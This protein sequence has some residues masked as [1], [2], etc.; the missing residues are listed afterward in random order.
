MRFG[1]PFAWLLLVLVSISLSSQA[2]NKA[3][4]S[5]AQLKSEQSIDPLQE[6]TNT[7]SIT[8]SITPIPLP[9]SS[10]T[11]LPLPTVLRPTPEIRPFELTNLIG[12]SDAA[13]RISVSNNRALVIAEGWLV[14]MDLSQPEAAVLSRY[15]LQSTPNDVQHESVS[16]KAFDVRGDRVA[17]IQDEKLRFLKH[18]SND[19]ERLTLVSEFQL[20]NSA[21]YIAGAGDVYLIGLVEPSRDILRYRAYRWEIGDN[22][23]EVAVVDIPETHVDS[24]QASEHLLAINRQ[25]DPP[26]GPRD[27]ALYDISE[28]DRPQKIASSTSSGR[29]DAIQNENILVVDDREPDGERLY[30]A[31]LLARNSGSLDSLGTWRG[32]FLRNAIFSEGSIL[33]ATD[34]RNE[35][36]FPL[37][38]RLHHL[39]ANDGTLNEVSTSDHLSS[40]SLEGFPWTFWKGDGRYCFPF[41]WRN[42][43]WIECTDSTWL[44]S[45][46]YPSRLAIDSEMR[47]DHAGDL[48]LSD[49][50]HWKGRDLVL[51]GDMISILEP[52]PGFEENSEAGILPPWRVVWKQDLSIGGKFLEAD[53]RLLSHAAG[54]SLREI[55]FSGNPAQPV[56]LTTIPPSFTDAETNG[57]LIAGVIKESANSSHIKVIDASN[58]QV[59]GETS[60]DSDN[61]IRDWVE[62]SSIFEGSKYYVPH[63]SKGWFVFDLADSSNPTLQ[64]LLQG[65]YPDGFFA[66]Q[67]Y[68][69]WVRDLPAVAGRHR[70]EL[71]VYNTASPIEDGQFQEVTKIALD[72]LP[73]SAD[74]NALGQAWR[75]YRLFASGNLLLIA[76]NGG[77]L[78]RVDISNPQSP[79]LLLPEPF[80]ANAWSGSPLDSLG[81]HVVNTGP[82]YL[83]EQQMSRKIPE[84]SELGTLRPLGTPRI[85]S[86]VLEMIFGSESLTTTAT[87]IPATGAMT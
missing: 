56:E 8:P 24:I 76:R 14:L 10:P 2:L 37:G 52:K 58:M 85:I 70:A 74:W 81:Q 11:T 75:R 40:Q 65:P 18:P 82:P 28:L 63:R 6:A 38:V 79:S 71:T 68:A 51:G 61:G 46:F 31:H 50:V 23:S 21:D 41:G 3:Y 19:S 13:V 9:S 43:H 66:Y 55:E 32:A 27:W 62:P 87:E 29:I 34:I 44:R 80:A 57:S 67:G 20:P 78:S 45:R 69:Y 77:W 4:T 59:V 64:G 17:F 60:F 16:I 1:R 12:R 36:G 7:P 25:E 48:A 53:G 54:G 22:P 83:V 84:H 26:L 42:K 86:S 5:Q 39:I 72:D 49:F 47:L 73:I 30:K 33:I 35:S 15:P